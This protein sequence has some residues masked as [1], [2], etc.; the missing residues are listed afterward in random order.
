MF[1]LNIRSIAK[2]DIQEIIDYYE[3]ISPKITDR[4][5]N[6][7]YNE[8]DF[9]KG[10]PNSFQVKYRN[11]R[12]RY[13]KLFPFGI[14]YKTSNNLIEILAILHTSRNPNSWRIN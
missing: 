11:T 1:Q 4:F 3:D 12:V 6:E 8:F 7:L 13:L 5:L 14:H 10:K 2:Q 9:L